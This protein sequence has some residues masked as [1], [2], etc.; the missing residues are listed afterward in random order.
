MNLEKIRQKA[1]IDASFW[2]NAW[3]S[4]ITHFL[5]EYFEIFACSVVAGEVQHVSSI[6]GRLIPSGQLFQDWLS[7]G[8]VQIQDPQKA[9][10][11]YHPGEN[12]A[13]GLAIERNYTVLIDDKHPYHLAKSRGIQV[14]TTPELI[15]LL[16]TKENL[17]YPA[18]RSALNNLKVDKQ[19]IRQIQ[20]FLATMAR[21]RGDA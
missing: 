12:A 16:Y 9:V 3:Q 15:A 7:A 8:Q 5:P 14:V 20:V 19:I 18:A 4:G 2:I 11:W 13:I 6:T 17:S 1:S 10:D 21:K